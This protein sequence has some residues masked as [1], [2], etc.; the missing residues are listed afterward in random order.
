MESFLFGLIL[1]P[2]EPYVHDL[3]LFLYG[4]VVDN[5]LGGGVSSLYLCLFMWKTHFLK[6]AVYWCLFSGIGL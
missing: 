2:I 6:H 1:D 4:V 5:N 3:G